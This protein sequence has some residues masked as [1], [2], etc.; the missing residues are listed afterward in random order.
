MD[1]NNTIIQHRQKK[2]T[3][4]TQLGSESIGI[5]TKRDEDHL[6]LIELEG[7]SIRLQMA[8]QSFLSHLKGN[9]GAYCCITHTHACS[10]DLRHRVPPRAAAAEPDDHRPQTKIHFC[11]EEMSKVE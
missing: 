10:G 5:V 7:T 4:Q 8:M 3:N 9:D 11:R 1:T 2:N 6:N